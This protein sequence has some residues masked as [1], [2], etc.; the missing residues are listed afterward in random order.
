MDALKADV[1]GKT[2]RVPS[3]DTAATLGASMLAGVGTGLYHSFGEA[4]GST[5]RIVRTYEPNLNRHTVYMKFYEI[6]LELYE[7]LKDS[8][9]KLDRIGQAAQC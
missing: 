4:V 3:S 1:T 7:K 5:V 6:Y 2:I 8:M 9:E